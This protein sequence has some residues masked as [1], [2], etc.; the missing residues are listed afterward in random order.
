MS[1]FLSASD[2][3]PLRAVASRKTGLGILSAV[4]GVLE[5]VLELQWLSAAGTGVDTSGECI[6]AALER[7][8]LAELVVEMSAEICTSS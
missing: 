5:V 3:D 1:S 8:A 2:K 7:V 4:S 6:C